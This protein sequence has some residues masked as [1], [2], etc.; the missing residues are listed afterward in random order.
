MSPPFVKRPLSI[1]SDKTSSRC[2]WIARF[3]G[4]APKWESK[5]FSAS[6]LLAPGVTS[7]VNPCCI[8]CSLRTFNWTSRIIGQYIQREYGYNYSIKGVTIILK[9]LNLSYTRPSY[10]LAKADK[11]KQEHFKTDFETLKKTLE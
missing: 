4:R 10:V 3:R 11:E 9:R 7:I 5:P 2:F 6:H 8:N 1:S